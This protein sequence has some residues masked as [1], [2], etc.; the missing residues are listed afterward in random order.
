MGVTPPTNAEPPPL[1]GPFPVQ[2]AE[3]QAK[4][5][6]TATF[7]ANCG[8]ERDYFTQ[9]RARDAEIE[10]LRERLARQDAVLEDVRAWQAVHPEGRVTHED[11]IRW[12]ERRVGLFDALH[13]LPVA[14]VE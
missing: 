1:R 3:Y 2:S 6:H 5:A 13:A 4:C 12:Y 14:P 9:L 7:C 11:A 10:G 8:Q